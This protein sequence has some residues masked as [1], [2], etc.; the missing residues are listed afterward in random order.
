MHLRNSC[1]RSTS[2]C[3]IRNSPGLID[4][5]R[6]NDGMAPPRGERRH[7]PHAAEPGHAVDLHGAG[8]ALAGLA[9]PPDGEIGRLRCLQPVQHV[10]DDLTLVDLDLVVL[11]L[12]GAGVAAPHPELSQVA[13]Q[14]SSSSAAA[15]GCP[16]SS[17]LVMYFLSS[18]MSNSASRS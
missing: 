16:A 5:S 9:V 17:S 15:L 3:C 13:H 2:S 10:K 4:G 6:M 12:T 11:Q 14:C 8:A 1:D 7:P 18:E